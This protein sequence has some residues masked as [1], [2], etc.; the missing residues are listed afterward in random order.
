MKDNKALDPLRMRLPGFQRIVMNPKFISDFI[1][2][3]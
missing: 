2:Q 3:F 1:K